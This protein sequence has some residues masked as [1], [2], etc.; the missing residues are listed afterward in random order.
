LRRVFDAQP[1][2]SGV[3]DPLESDDDFETLPFD[4]SVPSLTPAAVVDSGKSE[5]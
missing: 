2:Y 1:S 4:I 5:E 3:S